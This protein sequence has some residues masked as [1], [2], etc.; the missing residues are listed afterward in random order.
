[1]AFKIN[2]INTGSNGNAIL[3]DDAIMIDCGLPFKTLK[4][5]N[6]LDLDVLFITHRHG[7]HLNMSVLRNIDKLR[8]WN[9]LSSMIYT[10]KDV[11]EK[12]NTDK[13]LQD[14]VKNIIAHGDIFE[15]TANN[16]IYKVEVFKCAH[17]VE[18]TGFVFT[19]E[20]NETLIFAT[21][22]STMKYAPN[23]LYDYIVVEGNY[24]EVKLKTDQLSDNY[25]VRRRAFRNLR[26]LSIQ[27]FEDFVTNYSKPDSEVWQLHESNEYG[28]ISRLIRKRDSNI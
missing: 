1:M 13:K 17:D 21:D 25:E 9:K 24:D 14:K 5:Y 23:M 3:I 11:A 12:I 4:E 27:Q 2:I 7:D 18:N 8:P 10:N 19:N 28:A 16:K 22:T 26:H 20:E 15:I 6:I